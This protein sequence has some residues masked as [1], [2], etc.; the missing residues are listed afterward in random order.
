MG[1]MWQI[2]G[3]LLLCPHEQL[4][5]QRL[6]FDTRVTVLGHVQ[7]G[8]T[9]SAFDRI[10]VGGAS[11]WCWVCVRGWR[12]V[13]ACTGACVFTAASVHSETEAWQPRLPSLLAMTLMGPWGGGLGE[14]RV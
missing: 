12:G 8:G 2:Q 5:V 6:G 14:Q 7:R 4:V 13:C 10:L 11:P 1:K 9:P 3:P